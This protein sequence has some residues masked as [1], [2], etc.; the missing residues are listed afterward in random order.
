MQSTLHS[1]PLPQFHLPSSSP[2]NPLEANVPLS[3]HT[4]VDSPTNLFGAR[5]FLSS[6]VNTPSG[7]FGLTRAPPEASPPPEG[8]YDDQQEPSPL[9]IN[10]QALAMPMLPGA[11]RFTLLP[12]P[13]AL[14]EEMFTPPGRSVRTLTASV[15]LCKDNLSQ[16]LL[17]SKGKY[18][19]ICRLNFWRKDLLVYIIF[20]IFFLEFLDEPLDS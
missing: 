12:K 8:L 1:N 19:D 7:P 10:S 5:V 14:L 11:L 15:Q 6:R 17:G 4:P 18:I 2:S 16:F 3:Q 9:A 20:S 13:V